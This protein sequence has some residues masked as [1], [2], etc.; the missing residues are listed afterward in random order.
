M[1]VH[2]TQG[3]LQG[4]ERAEVLQEVQQQVKIAA[5]AAIKRFSRHSCKP[6]S[7]PNWDER[8]A[9]RDE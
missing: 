9:R 4:Q 7:R 8:K 6:N 1:S 5:L 2:F 3:K